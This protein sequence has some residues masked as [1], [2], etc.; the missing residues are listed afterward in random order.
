MLGDSGCDRR[1]VFGF[2]ELRSTSDS[3]AMK[4]EERR[5]RAVVSEDVDDI[6]EDI[7]WEG[8]KLDVG[9]SNFMLIK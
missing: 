4:G 5:E 7:L 2:R 6:G 8:A 9:D 1:G 3:L